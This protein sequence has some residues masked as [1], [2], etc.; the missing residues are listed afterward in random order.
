MVQEDW[1][2]PEMRV[3]V[4]VC[5][6]IWE[7]FIEKFSNKFPPN[8]SFK[9]TLLFERYSVHRIPHETIARFDKI[10]Q[11]LRGLVI[12]LIPRERQFD[13]SSGFFG[14]VLGLLDFY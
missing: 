2:K 4:S 7:I 14:N 8:F 3:F 11:E 6:L 5:L 10:P 9:T 12:H 13:K 1:T